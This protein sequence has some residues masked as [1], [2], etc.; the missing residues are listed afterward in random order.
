MKTFFKRAWRW[1]WLLPE[2][3]EPKTIGGIETDDTEAQQLYDRMLRVGCVE[4]RRQPPK[5]FEG[6]SGGLCTNIFCGWCGQGYNVTPMVGW[7]QKIRKDD[8]YI[9]KETQS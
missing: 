3:P 7:A 4:C 1:L 2:P 5:F 9:E 8:R 6:P